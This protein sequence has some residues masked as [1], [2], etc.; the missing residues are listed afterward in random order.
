LEA[1]KLWLGR[2]GPK[3][4]LFSV[5]VEKQESIAE[6]KESELKERELK[7][8]VTELKEKRENIKKKLLNTNVVV[9]K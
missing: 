3:K 5:V 4:K 9:N 2:P 8:S 7:E 1:T 6:L